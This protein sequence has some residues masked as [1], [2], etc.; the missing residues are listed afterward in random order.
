MIFVVICKDLIE[1]NIEAAVSSCLNAVCGEA[2]DDP[3]HKIFEAAQSENPTLVI[4][5]EVQDIETQPALIIPLP[6]PQLYGTVDPTKDLELLRPFLRGAVSSAV[7]IW[8]NV[9]EYGRDFDLGGI[10]YRRPYA[11]KNDLWHRTIVLVDVP[12]LSSAGRQSSLSGDLVVAAFGREEDGLP[13][14]EEFREGGGEALQSLIARVQAAITGTLPGNLR[15]ISE[16]PTS[17]PL[18]TTLRPI[19]VPAWH[20]FDRWMQVLHGT[21][22]GAFI[23]SPITGPQRVDGPAGSGKTLSLALKALWT[24]KTALA[25]GKPHHA[26]FIVFS[27]ETKHKILDSFLGPLDESD[28]HN[29]SRAAGDQQSL[30]VTTLLEWSRKE[31]ESVVGSFALPSESAAQA[32]KDQIELVRESLNRNLANFLRGAG[33][34]LSSDLRGLCQ[35]GATSILV[36]MFLHEYGVVIKGMA[37]SSLRRYLTIKRPRVA[38]PCGTEADRRFV[39]ALFEKYEELLREYGVVDL[40]DV[41]VSH[42][43]LLEMPLRREIREGVAFDSVFIDEAHSFNPN[44]LA[45][46]FLLARRAEFP[47]LVVAVDLPQAIGDKAYEGAGLESAIFEEFEAREALQ[48]QRFLLADIRR[49]PQSVLDVVSSIYSQ[50]ANYMQSVQMPTALTSSQAERGSPP[51]VRQFNSINEMLEGALE[52]GEEIVERLHCARSDVLVVLLHEGLE[53]AIPP[54]LRARSE[55]LTKRSDHDTERRAQ[56]AN[57]FVISRPE[58]LHGL[59]YEAV[60]LVGLSSDEVPRVEHVGLGAGCAALFETQ[61]VVDLLYLALTRARKEVSILFV[62]NPSFLLK[63]AIAGKLVTVQE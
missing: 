11:T 37:D 43:K 30:T 19:H 56:R 46:F 29:K 2:A 52:E 13:R 49:C 24:L 33:S 31:L 7:R 28:F 8:S 51:I 55:M 26:A 25:E 61:R 14:L 27:D 32:R 45:I 63:S 3:A 22:Q 41:A 38:L 60:I 12:H 47:P 40:D 42:I 53:G 15:P 36:E 17:L 48:V 50:G 21:Q 34:A 4:A 57:H 9:R 5:Y 10:F 16:A 54:R 58:Y 18:V 6:I 1:A 35:D 59:E 39:F 44:E 20:S 62:G 23:E